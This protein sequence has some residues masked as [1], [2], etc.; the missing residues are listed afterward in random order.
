MANPHEA[1]NRTKKAIK[2]ADVMAQAV[3]ALGCDPEVIL[4]ENSVETRRKCEIAA[5]VKPASRETWEL[6]VAMLRERDAAR[7]LYMPLNAP[8]QVAIPTPPAVASA[9]DSTGGV[10][11][12]IKKSI[13]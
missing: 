13:T 4:S 6:V 1:L 5:G 3:D 7:R 11:P 2:L 12:G 8:D 10:A 9:I